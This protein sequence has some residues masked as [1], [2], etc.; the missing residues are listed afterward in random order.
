MPN[1]SLP[2]ITDP[3]RIDGYSQPGSE[4]NTNPPDQ[5]INVVLKIELAGSNAGDWRKR[6]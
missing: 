2:P 3:V 6:R 5:G 4:P 1:T